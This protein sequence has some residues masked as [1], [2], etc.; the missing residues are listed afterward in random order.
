VPVSCCS[1]GGIRSVEDLMYDV[2]DWRLCTWSVKKGY[3]SA[4]G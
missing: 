4:K 1:V 3:A 2:K